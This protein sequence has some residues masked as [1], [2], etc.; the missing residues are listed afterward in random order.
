MHKRI[1]SIFTISLVIS[2]FGCA[3]QEETASATYTSSTTG[4]GGDISIEVTFKGDSIDNIEILKDNETAGV[5]EIALELMKEKV[6]SNQSVLVDTVSGT[7]ITSNAFLSAVKDT[8]KQANLENLFNKEI[9]QEVTNETYDYDVVVVGSGISGLCA[10]L[11]AVE[12]GANVAIIEK[13]G[14]VGGTSIFSSGIFLVA[15]D[16]SKIDTVTNTYLSRNKIQDKNQV[17][18]ELVSSMLSIGPDLMKMIQDTGLTYEMKNEVYF[19]PDPSEKA[20]QNASDI[21]LA[22]AKT[23]Q[24]GGEQLINCLKQAFVKNG[25]DIYLDTPATSLIQE[26][27]EVVGVVSKTDYST[28]TFHAKSVILAT[29]DYAQNADMTSELCPIAL[30]DYTA[31]AISNTGDGITMALEV[32]AVLDDFQESMSGIFAPDPYDMPVVG[33]PYNSYPYECLLVNSNGERKVSETAGTHDQM[34]YFVEENE[35]DYGWVIMD[36]EIANK[37]LHLDEYL[38]K[39]A[40]GSNVIQAYKEDSIE[41]LAEDIGMDTESLQNTINHYNELCLNGEDTDF[42]KDKEYLSA[43]DDGTYYAVK[44]YNCTRGNYGGIVTNENAEVINQDGSA[45]KGLYAT[46]I[47]SSGAY[48]GDYYPGCEALAL[49]AHMGYIAGEHAAN[50]SK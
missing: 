35:A 18:K 49:G 10:G 11:K 32:G 9:T 40:N 14:I 30:N 6:L 22:T 25:G 29:G 16:D 15:D 39:T 7:T 38:E 47:I 46:G 4:V 42:Q 44:E 41:K 23:K 24:K 50:Y 27:D 12:S 20:I 37:F 28:K 26:N 48:F 45:I 36:Q 34:I 3:K 17:D 8:I 43:I 19:Y 2:L 31:T 5:G 13:L 33:Q 21:T 1:L